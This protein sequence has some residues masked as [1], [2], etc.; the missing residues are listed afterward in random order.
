[1][2]I[3][4]FLVPSYKSKKLRT[5]C[6]SW[7]HLVPR[8]LR[9]QNYSQ[10]RESLCMIQEDN[11]CH[12]GKQKFVLSEK[13]PQNTLWNW[14]NRIENPTFTPL[15][16]VGDFVDAKDNIEVWGYAKIIDVRISSVTAGF[17][18][19]VKH[20]EFRVAFL[21]WSEKF[22]EWVPGDKVARLCTYTLDPKN[23]FG[24]LPVRVKSWALVKT[25]KGWGMYS[26]KVL[27]KKPEK[28]IIDA[29]NSRIL[30]DKNNPHEVIRIHSNVNTFLTL[31]GR[32]FSLKRK[33]SDR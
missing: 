13:W 25:P 3:L 21:G 9:S 2:S 23:I 28:V 29:D 5:V 24:T 26:I 11:R 16:Q 18:N 1:M 10:L 8:C 22:D 31:P 27:E 6:K 4:D 7:N 33:R 30:I 15:W 12:R 32:A 19:K 17:N 14:P 20:R